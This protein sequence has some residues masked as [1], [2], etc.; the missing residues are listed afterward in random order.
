MIEESYVSRDTARML[1]EAGFDVPCNSY[2]ERI[3][4][5]DLLPSNTGF[6][7]EVATRSTQN[8]GGC[9][10]HSATI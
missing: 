10:F 3:W 1:K 9:H 5:H 4:R 2:Y 6:G 7:G 8:S